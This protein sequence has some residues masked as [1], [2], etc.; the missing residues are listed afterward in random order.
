MALTASSARLR[1]VITAD[2]TSI[3]MLA[4]PRKPCASSS[5]SSGDCPAKGPLSASVMGMAML[6]TS[7]IP[8]T[9]PGCQNRRAAQTPSGNRMKM[10]AVSCEKTKALTAERRDRQRHGLRHPPG[11]PPV[12]PVGHRDQDR[13][14]DHQVPAHVAE[15]PGAPHGAEVAGGDLV[16][17][18]Q[19]GDADRGADGGA[20]G[21]P[22]NRQGDHIPDPLQ[23]GAEIRQLP[24]Q[25]G[26]GERLE[27]VPGR[28]PQHRVE[29][30]ARPGVRQQGAERH[31][32]PNAIA[33]QEDR[34]QRDPGG[35]PDRRHAR[36]GEGEVEAELCGAV[37][38]AGEHGDLRYV[39]LPTLAPPLHGDEP[40]AASLKDVVHGR[41]TPERP[42]VPPIAHIPG[43]SRV[44][45]EPPGIRQASFRGKPV[46]TGP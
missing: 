17:D 12:G 8:T 5:L 28:D 3:V 38:G 24:Q 45:G 40:S 23:R 16:G 19:A 25:V 26:A 10:S 15:P 20:H 22:E 11:R 36:G 13:R 35:R 37:V 1:S 42:S 4:M 21:A 32:G 33:P 43:R 34:G 7:R 41:G 30:H 9:V 18:Q 39:G 44:R 29:G 31:P 27:R 46:H 2:I 14:G 6:A